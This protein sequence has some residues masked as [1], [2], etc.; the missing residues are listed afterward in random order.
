MKSITYLKLF[1]RETCKHTQF[2]QGW[3]FLFRR[4]ARRGFGTRCGRQRCR[5]GTFGL[6]LGIPYVFNQLDWRTTHGLLN[7][8]RGCK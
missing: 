2:V 7:Q 4:T 6:D 1:Y 8:V 5:L 3:C